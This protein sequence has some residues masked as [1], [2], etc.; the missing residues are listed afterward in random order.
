MQIG[1]EYSS[2][3]GVLRPK[4][5]IHVFT[6][7]HPASEHTHERSGNE[8]VKDVFQ[9]QDIYSLHQKRRKVDCSGGLRDQIP[10]LFE[11][12]IRYHSSAILSEQYQV[13]LLRSTRSRSRC[14][15]ALAGHICR[16]T[17]LNAVADLV[18]RR[19]EVISARERFGRIRWRQRS[20]LC[21][22]GVFRGR[23]SPDPRISVKTAFRVSIMWS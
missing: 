10:H 22:A 12:L 17:R 11:V 18:S 16:Q 5:N 14:R 21:E 15:S 2:G 4:F 3:S 8:H 9:S 20:V 19:A 6:R 13:V 7:T 1:M 23:I